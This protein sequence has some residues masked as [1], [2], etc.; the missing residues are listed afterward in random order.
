MPVDVTAEVHPGD[1]F[2]TGVT[3]LRVRDR[4]Q[5][6]EVRFLWNGR[7]VDIDSPFRSTGLDARD[8]PG[9]QPAR[10][11]AQLD[12]ATPQLGAGFHRED[13]LETI[14]TDVRHAGDERRVTVELSGRTR[15]RR[16][17][18]ERVRR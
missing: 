18:R 2:L 14:Q 13:D 17:R 1:G 12:G 11:G 7:I 4:V 5:L 15:V 9:V 8:V 10:H 3:P 6:V 16:E